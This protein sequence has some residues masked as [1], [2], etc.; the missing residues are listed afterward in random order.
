[1]MDLKSALGVLGLSPEEC[2]ETAI[3]HNWR[4]RARH[5]HPDK[6]PGLEE[7]F[8]QL[9]TALE[10][11]LK[12]L[13]N[14]LV[15]AAAALAGAPGPVQ[16]QRNR[17]AGATDRHG[18]DV[19]QD[20]IAA[21]ASTKPMRESER[22]D[23][24]AFGTQFGSD[25]IDFRYF[26]PAPIDLLLAGLTRSRTGSFA[27][28]QL[29]DKGERSSDP[30]LQLEGLSGDC[31]LAQRGEHA[32]TMLAIATQQLQL[33]IAQNNGAFDLSTSANFQM[34]W[35]C[36]KCDPAS[37]TCCRLKPK[38]ALCICGHKLCD[39]VFSKNGTIGNGFR[40]KK[41]P[42][43]AFKYHVQQGA[44][45][46]RCACK[47]KRVDHKP[48]ML[49]DGKT[50]VF[51]CCGHVPGQRNKKCGCKDFE[52]SWVCNCGHSWADHETVLCYVGGYGSLSKA[53]FGREWV[54]GGLR[55][56]CVEIAEQARDKWAGQAA[57]QVAMGVLSGEEAKKKAGRFTERLKISRV[58]E[59]RMQEAVDDLGTQLEAP[60]KQMK[61]VFPKQGIA[62]RSKP[63][64]DDRTP[65]VAKVGEVFSG[66]VY[67]TWFK[68]TDTG[69]LEDLFLPLYSKD[70]KHTIL[71]EVPSFG[72]TLQR[73]VQNA[74]YE[75]LE[76]EVVE[77]IPDE[78]DESF[79]E[80]HGGARGGV[81]HRQEVQV[82]DLR[83]SSDQHRPVSTAGSSRSTDEQLRSTST[84]AGAFSQKISF[85]SYFERN[86]K[87]FSD[88]IPLEGAVAEKGQDTALSERRGT[89][90]N[91]TQRACT[92]MPYG[93]RRDHAEQPV[94]PS[95]VNK[96]SAQ[97]PRLNLL[98]RKIGRP[99][100]EP[101]PRQPMRTF[102][103]AEEQARAQLWRP[104]SVA[105]VSSVDVNGDDGFGDVIFDETEPEAEQV[106]DEVHLQKLKAN[107]LK[108]F[109]PSSE[110]M[111]PGDEDPGF[112][113]LMGSQ[114]RSTTTS[115]RTAG[116]CADHDRVSEAKA[117]I[118]R[119]TLLKR[120]LRAKA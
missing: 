2:N 46:V 104:L 67:S 12:A 56:E 105:E 90:E 72:A 85:A 27:G 3:R 112:M 62:F 75:A 108:V 76:E 21:P 89:P 86:A 102:Q 29:Q 64:F 117:P 88:T 66:R 63:Q 6:N 5:C 49:P 44:W 99:R 19:V 13:Q 96:T 60:P 77:E 41:G 98:K 22:L 25:K 45:E 55:V 4:L 30:H 37:S 38:K 71:E 120:K 65:K 114:S 109:P 61:V 42:C 58:A 11:V 83:K 111:S 8:A 51:T 74:E 92:E 34:V 94:R 84:G 14:G 43:R 9:Q 95:P 28:A 97:E 39:H 106:E 17:T 73:S 15:G 18:A 40:S 82:V 24:F 16:A 33:E 68:V 23:K 1:M 93:G 69:D 101:P 116:E 35:R 48:H 115:A 87:L 113:Q 80:T 103:A 78:E 59:A 119:L 36:K 32:D 107:I 81:E 118:A 70:G 54:S 10:L 53:L 110:A 20:E 91:G 100:A 26:Q 79:G 52:A 31:A 50:Q 47:H 57:E 7:D